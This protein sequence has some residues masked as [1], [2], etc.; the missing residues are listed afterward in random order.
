LA[1]QSIDDLL[2]VGGL[3]EERAAALIMKAREPWF[4]EQDNA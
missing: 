2:E 4:A 3:D 1:E